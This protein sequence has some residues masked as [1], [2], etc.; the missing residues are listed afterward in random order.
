[1][2]LNCTSHAMREEVLRS[3]LAIGYIGGSAMEVYRFGETPLMLENYLGPCRICPGQFSADGRLIVWQLVRPYWKEGQPSLVV[4]T[5]E[6]KPVNEWWGQLDALDIKL[7]SALSPDRSMIALD[8][9]SY[10]PG[11]TNTGLQY[12]RLGSDKRIILERQPQENELEASETLGWSPDSK[13]I[14]FSRHG[15]IT[16]INIDTGERIDVASGVDPSWSP[17]GHWISFTSPDHRPML[18]DPTTKVQVS[19]FGGRPITGT[20]AW[21]P[22]SRYVSFS[23]AGN[24]GENLLTI[25][26][27]RL[28]VYRI[29][30]GRWFVLARFSPK[31]GRAIDFG[32]FYGPE[33][34]IKASM[35]GEP[36]NVINDQ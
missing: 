35:R 29:Q 18:L 17:D 9:R 22:D 28:I 26:S 14:V 16:S 5:V 11:A 2:A 30:D 32:W 36:N 34:L 15:R 8:L 10:R 31:G 12:V 1:M 19:L 27:G 7:G 23:D 33:D 25:S 24:S 6:G 3:G 13:R 21:S 4:T 20:I